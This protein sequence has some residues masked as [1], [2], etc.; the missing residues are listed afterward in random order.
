MVIPQRYIIG[1]SHYE[2]YAK[3]YEACYLLYL[4]PSRLALFLEIF[5][6]RQ[7]I[8]Q[9]LHYDG[10]I[11]I[12]LNGQRQQRSLRKRTAGKNIHI[13]QEVAVRKHIAYRVRIHERDRNVTA[14][15]EYENYQ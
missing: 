11:D 13:T 7:R 5:Q 9:K 8:G 1:I 3:R 12:R 14:Y 2:R 6:R 15:P 4:F 10:S